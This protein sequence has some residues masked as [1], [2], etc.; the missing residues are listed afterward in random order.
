MAANVRESLLENS[1]ESGD[2]FLIERRILHSGLKTGLHPGAGTEFLNLP[3]KRGRKIQMVQNFRSKFCDDSA[4]G[5]DRII[6][7]IGHGAELLNNLLS[8]RGVRRLQH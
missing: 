1:K 4:N 3:F 8:G 7:Q 2:T 6:D 5:T